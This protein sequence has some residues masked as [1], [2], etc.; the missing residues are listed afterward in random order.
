MKEKMAKLDKHSSRWI[1]LLI[2]GKAIISRTLGTMQEPFHLTLITVFPCYEGLFVE[3]MEL[4]DVT[5]ISWGEH[6]VTQHFNT[7]ALFISSF[8]G[9]GCCLEDE[10]YLQI[11]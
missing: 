8:L 4:V 3:K 6:G 9:K 1:P 11:N 7:F 10:I 2:K 5:S